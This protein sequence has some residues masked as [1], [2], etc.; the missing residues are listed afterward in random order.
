MLAQDENVQ[1]VLSKA[2]GYTARLSMVLHC[3]EQAVS[4]V[5]SQTFDDTASQPLWDLEITAKAVNSAAA[6]I[7][8]LNTLKLL[9]NT[10]VKKWARAIQSQ[11]PS[12][13]WL[14]QQKWDLAL[15]RQ[16]QQQTTALLNAFEKDACH[17]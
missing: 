7:Q 2:R 1:G 17:N 11:R 4:R 16:P 14:M 10:S 9:K 6:I 8:H 13:S 15:W 3:L 12:I 5:I